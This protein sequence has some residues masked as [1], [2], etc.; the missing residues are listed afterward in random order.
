M[1]TIEELKIK[2]TAQDTPDH[3]FWIAAT[4]PQ[5]YLRYMERIVTQEIP[6]EFVKRYVNENYDLLVSKLDREELKKLIATIIAE[7][8]LI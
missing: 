8:L 3:N 6:K 4:M 1:E 2:I 7:K 5:A